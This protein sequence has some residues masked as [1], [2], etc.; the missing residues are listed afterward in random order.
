MALPN[1]GVSRRFLLVVCTNHICYLV[2]P[3]NTAR[4]PRK[5][6]TLTAVPTPPKQGGISLLFQYLKEWWRALI[7]VYDQN[8]R[9]V[10]AVLWTI[11]F[12]IS[13]FWGVGILPPHTRIEVVIIDCRVTDCNKKMQDYIVELRNLR[14]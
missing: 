2:I 12:L 14:K 3:I 8:Q 10:L 11:A 1:C 5:R 4:K 7:A 6:P 9:T 13:L